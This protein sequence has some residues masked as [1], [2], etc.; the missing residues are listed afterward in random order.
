MKVRKMNLIWILLIIA[1]VIF[2]RLRVTPSIALPE[3]FTKQ[4][5]E[6]L[7]P[8]QLAD[9]PL[10]GEAWALSKNSTG[11][12]FVSAYKN[13][14]VVRVFTSSGLAEREPSGVNYVTNGTIHLGHVLYQATSIHLNASGKSGY[15]VFEPV[16]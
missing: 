11:K 9:I 12:V 16:A 10:K 7:I 8:V 6:V 4:G 15:I 14:R 13:D 1:A 5:K 2:F 3:H